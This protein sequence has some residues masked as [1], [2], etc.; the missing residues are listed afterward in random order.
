MPINISQESYEKVKRSSSPVVIPKKVKRMK[1]EQVDENENAED[2]TM[3]IMSRH[4]IL[5]SMSNDPE[6][7]KKIVR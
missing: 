5:F 1:T 4:R 6:E 3:Q 2:A 7:L